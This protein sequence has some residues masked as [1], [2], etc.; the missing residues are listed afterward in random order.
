MALFNKSH[1]G[2]RQEPGSW[3]CVCISISLAQM[4]R[5]R[6]IMSIDI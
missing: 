5:G 3:L 1:V 4:S 2:F 6:S